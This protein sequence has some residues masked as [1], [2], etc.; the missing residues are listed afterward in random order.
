MQLAKWYCED[1]A[2]DIALQINLIIPQNADTV[3]DVFDRLGVEYKRA[4]ALDETDVVKISEEA[5]AHDCDLVIAADCGAVVNILKDEVMLVADDVE[6]VLYATE[7][8]MRGFDVPWSFVSPIKNQPWTMF[9]VLGESNGQQL[10]QD[11]NESA[12]AKPEVADVMRSLVV[13]SI[14][15]LCFNRDRIEFYRQQD[16]WAER[17]NM[18]RQD[19]RFEYTNALNLFYLTLYSAVDQ[20]VALVVHFYTLPVDERDQGAGYGAFIKAR[21]TVP[22]LDEVFSDA[23]FDEMYRIPRLIRHKAAHRGPITPQTLYFSDDEYTDEQLDAAAE[24]NGYYDDLHVLEALPFPLPDVI[25][26][27][28]IS[29]ARHKAKLK[30]FGDPAK[31]LIYLEDKTGAFYYHPDPAGNLANFFAF[32]ERVLV[33]IKPWN[34]MNPQPTA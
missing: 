18:E 17:N 20:V 29:L 10:W 30:L 24:E 3:R 7:I 34:K 31:H 1:I 22:G 9:Y 28:M 11:M 13:D 23:Q 2:D 21:K 14:P 19:F 32:L 6:T 4:A 8:H 5:F 27:H 26:Y 25:R 16:R 33:L 12:Q 15:S